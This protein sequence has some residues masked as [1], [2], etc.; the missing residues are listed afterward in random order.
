MVLLHE[1]SH[2]KRPQAVSYRIAGK[3]ERIGLAQVSCSGGRMT[4]NLNVIKKTIEDGKKQQVDLLVF[5]ELCIPG[6]C[7][8]DLAYSA[9]FLK[10]N[11]E[12]LREIIECSDGIAVVVGFI[13]EDQENQA[14]GQRPWIYNS[15]AFIHDRKL[16]YIQHKELLPNYGVFNEKRYFQ[17]GTKPAIL[18]FDDGHQVGMAICEDLWADDNQTD[19]LDMLTS[20]GANVI[21][22]INASPFHQ[23]HV[24]ERMRVLTNAAQKHAVHLV[25][26]NSVGSFDA[27]DGELVFDGRSMVLNPIGQCLGMAKAF[28]EELKI[29]DLRQPVVDSFQWRE[30]SVNEVHDALILGIQQFFKRKGLTK[31]YIGLSGGIDCAVVAALAVK[32]LGAD[33]VTGITMPSFITS[34]E[35]KQDAW[36]LAKQLGIQCIER[37]IHDEYSS[38]LKNFMLTHATEPKSLTKQNKQARIRQSILMEYTNEDPGSVLLNTG[39]KTE[40]ALGYFTLGGDSAG[41]LSVI[42]DIH[43]TL[44]YE[45]ADYLNMTAK[46]ARIPCSIIHRAPTAEL[47]EGQTDEACLPAPYCV[48]VPLI[49]Q[50]MEESTAYHVLLKQYDKKVLDAVIA[51]IAKAE[52]KRRQLPPAIRVSKKSFG[53]E[54][55]IP[56]DHT[57]KRV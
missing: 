44:V 36:L 37:P 24:S 54:R 4:E 7:A 31:A 23:G 8:M 29:I 15:A 38:W 51:M 17:A 27:Y 26:S 11:R 52:G 46:Q 1:I 57:F 47:E 33:Q 45:L 55:R 53:I 21:V 9:D 50:I 35:T 18:A 40:I 20:I 49:Q 30:D 3:L 10:E 22:S 42:G 6:Y 14:P 13:D 5:P 2:T 32:A 41:A 39:N 28:Q 48:L 43:K 56:M 12:A 25:Y 16:H 19:V 34:S